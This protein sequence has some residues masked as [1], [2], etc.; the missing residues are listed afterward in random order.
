MKFINWD[1]IKYALQNLSHRKLRSFLTI[2][3]I[4]IGITAIFALVSFG[5]GIQSYVDTLATQSGTDKLFIMSKTMGAPGTDQTFYVSQ[6]DIDFVSKINGVK[7]IS[8]MY[9]K[10]AE[11]IFKEKKR[12]NYLVGID[13]SKI[14]GS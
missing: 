6:D 4:M 12:Y 10:P 2:I 9:M 3:S 1:E 5:L 7:E 8:G 14:E 13:M 11:I